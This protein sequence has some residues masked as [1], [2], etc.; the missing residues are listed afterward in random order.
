MIKTAVKTVYSVSILMTSLKARL[1]LHVLTRGTTS[2]STD[3]SCVYVCA[4]LTSEF[5]A[6]DCETRVWFHVC[7]TWGTTNGPTIGWLQWIK[8]CNSCCWFE[9]RKL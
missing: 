1:H 6:S 3:P 7:V 2:P 4:N 8:Y 9:D 5:T